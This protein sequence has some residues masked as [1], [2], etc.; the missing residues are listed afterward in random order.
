MALK[1]YG[2][3]FS[4]NVQRVVVVLK[5]K[6]LDFELLPVDMMN[7]EH[8]SEAYLSKQPF[9]VIP[10]LDDDGFLV[11]E[12]RAICRYLEAKFK[13]RGTPLIPSTEDIQAFGLFEQGASIETSYFDPTVHGL[14]MELFFKKMFHLGDTDPER[15]KILSQKLVTYLDAYE[16]I[17]SKQEYIGGNALTLADLFHLPVGR[18]LFHPQVNMAHVM[19]ERPHVK[20]WWEKISSRESWKQTVQLAEAQNFE[21]KK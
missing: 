12:S 15:V 8:K 17:L 20:A 6:N 19:M 10:V 5:E 21:Y 13:D 7:G 3:Y 18:S 14:A 11:Y 9:G 4:S 16:R 1:L 2:H